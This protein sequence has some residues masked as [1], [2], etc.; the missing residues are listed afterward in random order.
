M[1]TRATTDK[2]IVEVVSVNPRRFTPKK[3]EELVRDGVERT[4]GYAKPT[5]PL[6]VRMYL[7][8][9]NPTGYPDPANLPVHNVLLALTVDVPI[10]TDEFSQ[11]FSQEFI[12]DYVKPVAMGVSGI[13][14]NG[15]DTA[16][17]YFVVDL[18]PTTPAR[19]A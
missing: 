10:T 1:K 2:Y 18:L 12:K 4:L 13:G 15:G 8:N 19:L 9:L 5:G 17:V 7:T 6:K 3:A 11:E 16:T 14:V